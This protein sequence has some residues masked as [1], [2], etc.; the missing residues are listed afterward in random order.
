MKRIIEFDSHWLLKRIDPVEELDISRLDDLLRDG[1]ENGDLL[2][3]VPKMPSQVY[4]VLVSYGVIENPNT[5]G[6][7]TSC[8]WVAESDWLYLKDF[9]CPEKAGNAYLDFQGLDTYADIYLNGVLLARHE[10]V[11]LP[12]QVDI[13]GKI[14]ENNRLILHFHSPKKKFRDVVLPDYVKD[15]SGKIKPGARTRMFG[16]TFGDYLGPKPSLFRVGVY[17]AVSLVLVDQAEISG[18]HASYTLSE[19]FDSAELN[20]EISLRG[21]AAGAYVRIFVIDPEGKEIHPLNHFANSMNGFDIDG[22]E[23]LNVD[24]KIDKPAL[25]WPRTHGASPLYTVHAELTAGLKIADARSFKIGF[26]NI[27]KK[28]DFDFIINGLPL[29][30]WGSNLAP[31]DTLTNVYNPDRMNILLDLVELSHQNCL[32][33]WGENERIREDFYNECDR[34]GILV[35]QDFFTTYSMYD[36]NER[37]FD[38]LKAEAEYQ[39]GRLRDHPCI[40]LW[41]GG[42]ESI[43]SGQFDYPGEETLGLQIFDE[44]F[45][46]VCANLDPGRY[47]HRSSPDG[48]AYAND[49]LAGDTHGYTHIWY[50]PGNQYP[51]FLS[52]NNRVS[53]PAKRTMQRMMNGDDLWPAGY[54]GLQHKNSELP[55]PEAWNKYN[56]NQGYWKLGAVEAY[57][58][59]ADLDSMLYRIGWAHGDYLRRSIERYRR[60]RSAWDQGGQRITKGHILWKLNNSCNHIFFGVI[61]YFLEP[62]IA[63]YCLKRAYEPVLLSFEVGNF[64]DLWMINDTVKPL[65]GRVFIRLFDPFRNCVTDEFNLPFEIAPDESRLLTNLNRFGQFKKNC[66]LHAYA[67]ANDGK[68]IAESFDYVDIERHLRFPKDGVIKAGFKNGEIFLQ[69]TRYERS[70]ELL[71]R[72]EDGNEFG[73]LFDD[74]YF[75]LLPGQIKRVR[76][77]R[78]HDRGVISIKGYY[79]DTTTRLEYSR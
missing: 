55:W 1:P 2:F 9:S 77:L 46:E 47:Y 71:G 70:V 24:F 76:I 17:D 13:T 27:V 23:T 25:W 43:M 35:W 38:L 64:I 30:V 51:V 36:V 15:A 73:W 74:N 53:T 41:C 6:D 28:G 26:R 4:E 62:Y 3:T 72:A 49:P 45:P 21:Q 58:D 52:E 67:V 50:V 54:D 40:W 33:V 61:D 29:K 7:S 5:H 20:V 56:S 18:T 11:Y 34:R 65:A 66:I 10:D 14:L 48:G 63:Y 12:R 69:S 8:Q 31:M 39:V 79:S 57:Y 59:A 75:D 19:N 68:R 37:I 78:S 44:I 16:T 60:G 32:R 22:E 42:N